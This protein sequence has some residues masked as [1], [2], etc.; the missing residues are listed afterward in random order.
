MATKE[1]I[2][3]LLKKDIISVKEAVEML[4]NRTNHLAGGTL[5]QEGCTEIPYR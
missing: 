5:H 2:L 4:N 1:E 3:T